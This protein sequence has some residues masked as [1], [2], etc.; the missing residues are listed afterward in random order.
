LTYRFRE[1]THAYWKYSR[2]WKGGHFNAT[3]SRAGVTAADPEEIDAFEA[4]LRGSWFQGRLNLD[5]SIFYYNY[6]DY[7]IFT[8][9]QKQD[10]Q[11]EFVII[12]ANDAEV[13]GSEVDL[14]ARPLPGMFLNARFAWLESQFL[15]FVQ[16]LSTRSQFGGT[17]DIID[18]EIQNSGN[19]LLNSPQFKLSLTA[20]QTMPL[21]RYGSMTARWDGAWTDDVNF[22]AT[23]SRGIPN[24][25]GD[26]FLPE[27]TIGQKQYW[28][29]NLRLSYRT[30]N[31]AVE[32]SGW[33]R[34]LKDKDY[35]T[36]AFDGSTFNNTTIYFVGEPRTYGLTVSTTF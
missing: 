23:A 10:G 24:A 4:G 8:T 13:Y 33:V 3:T 2:G 15:D 12:N 7:Q 32:L 35:K 16:N 25:A 17:P 22:D 19:P 36:F 29:H 11:P 5:F 21:G 34:N 18:I 6:N 14:I 26:Q 31:G 30:P 27:H 9:E 20:E 28:L 1:D